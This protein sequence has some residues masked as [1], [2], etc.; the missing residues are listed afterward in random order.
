MAKI[1][2]NTLRRILKAAEFASVAHVGL[3][4]TATEAG[5]LEGLLTE[6]V[7]ALETQDK[8]NAGILPQPIYENLEDLV[9]DLPTPVWACNLGAGGIIYASGPRPGPDPETGEQL[10][11]TQISGLPYMA[12]AINGIGGNRADFGSYR[13]ATQPGPPTF[14]PAFARQDVL[15]KY[16]ITNAEYYAICE[17]IK[18]SEGHPVVWYSEKSTGGLK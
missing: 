8:I 18:H 16:G 7:N 1:A 13:I 3:A 5:D 9:A 4:L 12:L 10:E 14:T 11:W 2:L 15:D 6:I 17:A